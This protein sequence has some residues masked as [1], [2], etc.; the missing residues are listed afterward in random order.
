MTRYR[1]YKFAAF[2]FFSLFSAAIALKPTFSFAQGEVALIDLQIKRPDQ[3]DM[4]KLPKGHVFCFLR[5]NEVQLTV[6]NANYSY[7]SALFKLSKELNRSE[8]IL[9][10]RDSVAHT[11]Y[12]FNKKA[13]S[14]QAFKIDLAMATT[15]TFDCGTIPSDESFLTAV[16]IK[17]RFYMLTVSK[18]TAEIHLWKSERG[19]ALEKTS[20][21]IAQTK[22]HR[23][24]ETR[25]EE[26][27]EKKFSAIGIDK[28]D[29]ALENNL[30]SAH[31]LNK[32]YVIGNKIIVTVDDPDK[33][34]LYT[35]D[36]DA[37][38]L[39]EKDYTFTLEKN[40]NARDK[41]GNSFLLNN[42]LFRTTMNSEMMN[43]SMVSV[44]SAKLLWKYNVLPDEP[45]A[46]KNGPLLLEEDGVNKVLGKTGQYFNRVLS[47]KLCIAVNEINDHYLLQVGSYEYKDSWNTVGSGPNISI[48]MGMGMGLGMGYS[49]PSVGGY[50]WGMPGYYSGYPGYYPN[51]S[52]TYIQTAYFYS[53]L[54]AESLEHSTFPPPK[55][56]R[57]KLNEYET[58]KFKKNLPDLINISPLPGKFI[59]LGY[60]ARKNHKYQLV[61]IR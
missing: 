44:D 52:Y 13:N 7:S 38:T 59:L 25:E 45:I 8:Y 55:T 32:L 47:G 4:I 34:L 2:L 57:E 9:S 36:I 54:N 3:I 49:T 11:L 21:A 23:Y 30:K 41:Q 50:G 58:Q 5:N 29:Y 31:A 33:T 12:Y 18:N 40:D 14:I 20:F 39:V 28:I 6:L 19:M 51:S 48:G 15:Q 27:N 24:L 35:I 56:M 26:L 61:E 53:L 22:L 42:T 1:S 16:N 37:K 10:T 17:E 60:Y 46:I 43:L